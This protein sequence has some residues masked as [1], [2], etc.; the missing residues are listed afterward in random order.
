MA[1]FQFFGEG[2]S[3]KLGIQFLYGAVLGGIGPPRQVCFSIIENSSGKSR[4]F[5]IRPLGICRVGTQE[6]PEPGIE[7][8]RLLPEEFSIIEKHT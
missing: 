8:L 4:K 2:G 6:N 1:V 7:I 3:K 5:S